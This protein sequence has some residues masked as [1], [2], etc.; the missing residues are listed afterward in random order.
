MQQAITDEWIALIQRQ[1]GNTAGLWVQKGSET[2]CEWYPQGF[3][4]DTAVQVFSV[5]KSILSLLV[6]IAVDRG[7]IGSVEQKVLDFFPTYAVKRREKTIQQIT[8]RH[9]LTMTAPYKYQSPPYTRYFSS[10]SWVKT[11]LDLLGGR[12]EIG[13]FRYTP[14]IGPDILSG[15]L[16]AATG[17]AV[18]RFARQA[19]F[20]PLGIA[21][22]Q[23]IVFQT[24][25]EQID[26]MKNRRAPGWV[27]D[28]QG[29]NAAGWGL[30]VTL[31]DLA[32]IGRL[33][34]NRGMWHGKQVVSD[35]WMAQCTAVHSRWDALAYGYLWWIVDEKAS[36]F[37]ALGDGGNVIYVNPQKNVVIAM[38]AR[39][40]PRARDRIALIREQIEPRL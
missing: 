22:T 40:Q 39:F 16:A 34:L 17:Q 25:D 28:P 29:I 31:A 11:A 33:C 9:L 1:Y 5:T 15:V 12:G 36:A 21:V 10:E 23:N 32:K 27:A 13:A 2:L 24:K 7:L 20:E 3:G 37:A 4:P 30:F 35:T 8:L 19:L 38:T 6:G 18:L 26:I 14:L